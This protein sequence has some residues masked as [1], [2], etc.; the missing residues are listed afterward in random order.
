[1][2]LVL[3]PLHNMANANIPIKCMLI[4]FFISK[5]YLVCI[6]ALELCKGMDKILFAEMRLLFLLFTLA[7]K[8]GFIEQKFFRI[9]WD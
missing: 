4:S 3:H 5:S 9:L 6:C 8:G 1:M 2:R 7:G